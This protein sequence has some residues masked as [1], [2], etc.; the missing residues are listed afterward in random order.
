[1]YVFDFVSEAA[2]PP[3]VRSLVDGV[4][5]V[6]V[7]RLPFLKKKKKKENRC[8]HQEFFRLEPTE[9]RELKKPSLP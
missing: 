2:D 1:M 5:D 3:L 7:E 8:K 4:D 9:Q 6:G